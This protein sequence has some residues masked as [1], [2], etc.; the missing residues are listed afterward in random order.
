MQ[1]QSV[2]L[3]YATFSHELYFFTFCT[4]THPVLR[5]MQKKRPLR[6]SLWVH[7]G[8]CKPAVRGLLAGLAKVRRQ[9]CTHFAPPEHALLRTKGFSGASGEA[10][11]RGLNLFADMVAAC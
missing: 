5:G 8:C 6:C 10:T 9:T 11:A 4:G 1:V 3:Y 2:K 7:V